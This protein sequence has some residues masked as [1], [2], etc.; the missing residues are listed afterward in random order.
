MVGARQGCRRAQLRCSL[1]DSQ[2]GRDRGCSD[3]SDR[4]ETGK[5]TAITAGTP[6]TVSGVATRSV[7]STS[8]RFPSRMAV[9][10]LCAADNEA[11]SVTP[12]FG[13]VA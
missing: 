11:A 1:R 13:T 6:M 4:E 3:L 12:H 9:M 8:C 2:Q 10:N 7:S 5:C